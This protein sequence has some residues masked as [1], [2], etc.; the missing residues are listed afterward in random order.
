MS[1][2]ITQA[3]NARGL[4]QVQLAAQIG[5]H[6]VTV[7][8][9]EAGDVRP[10]RHFP[11]LCAALNV[12]V[13][14]L[15]DGGETEP[16]KLFRGDLPALAREAKERAVMFEFFLHQM[17]PR[18]PKE[19]KALERFSK[20][21]WNGLKSQAEILADLVVDMKSNPGTADV[22]FDLIKG[23]AE[24]AA[25][26]RDN[27]RGVVSKIDQSVSPW[28]AEHQRGLDEFVDR[29][30]SIVNYLERAKAA[31]EVFKDQPK[32]MTNEEIERRSNPWPK[33]WPK[34]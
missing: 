20:A 15:L 2:R 4:T 8:K 33:N 28:L 1:D 34:G 22:K 25:A 24:T 29:L 9:W 23:L 11:E 31:R 21:H 12:T 14:W 27:F 32:N 16:P 7:A 26:R 18:A 3:R 6:P 13:G 17:K 30:Q 10:G 5:V 19:A